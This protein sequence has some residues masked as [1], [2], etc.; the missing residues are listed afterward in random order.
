[1]RCLKGF[2]FYLIAIYRH[3]SKFIYKIV[4]VIKAKL[5]RKVLHVAP[6]VIGMEYRVRDINSWLRNTSADVGIAVICGMGGIGKTT[7]AKDVYNSNF[8]KFEGSSFLAS[9]REISEQPNGL[10]RLQRQLLSDILK[11]KREHINN[12]DEGI[13]KIKDAICCKR[14]IVIL[15]MSITWTNYMH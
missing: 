5:N 9:I 1:M 15:E 12:V 13:V 6:Y 7:I 10:V 2:T 8:N 4:K 3:E 14:V 11:V